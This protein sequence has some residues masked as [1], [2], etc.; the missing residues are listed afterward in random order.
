VVA[1]AVTATASVCGPSSE[2]MWQ[3]LRP[4]DADTIWLPAATPASV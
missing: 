4:I 2:P 1:F 3:T